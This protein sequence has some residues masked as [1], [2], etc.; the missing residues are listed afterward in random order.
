MKTVRKVLVGI[1]CTQVV[2]IAAAVCV[3]A[4]VNSFGAKGDGHTDDTAAI[5]AAINAAGSAGGGSVV[6]NVARYFTTGSFVVPRGVVLCG[7]IE[8]PFD[9]TGIDPAQT[10]VAP[11]ISHYQP[12]RSVSD[13]IRIRGR[14]D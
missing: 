4:S 14:C 10:T 12:E 9:V 8:G 5:Q 11:T 1:F 2:S 13:L 7:V 3:G 6:F